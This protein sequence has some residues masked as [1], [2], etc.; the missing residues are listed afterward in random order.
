MSVGIQAMKDVYTKFF[1]KGQVGDWKNYFEGEN[2]SQWD[3]WIAENLK[4]TDL[5]MVF[6]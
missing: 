6:E 1:R 4:G 2:L 3:Q 5:E